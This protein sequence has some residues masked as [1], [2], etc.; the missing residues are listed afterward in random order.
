MSS[1]T[2]KELQEIIANLK[3]EMMD[4]IWA[5][6]NPYKRTAIKD[7]YETRIKNWSYELA[8]RQSKVQS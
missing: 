8:E 4:R 3:D 2:K 7:E 5:E 1:F 6:P